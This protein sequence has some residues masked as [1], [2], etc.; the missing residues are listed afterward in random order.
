MRC[1]WKVN[2]SSFRGGAASSNASMD[3]AEIQEPSD[4]I[5]LDNLA[6]PAVFTWSA[7]ESAVLQDMVV[8][9]KAYGLDMQQ[10]WELS[11]LSEINL[12]D[13]YL[14][15]KTS[16]GGVCG[17]HAVF[18]SPRHG[19]FYCA[20]ARE[21][22]QTLLGPSLQHLRNALP[23]NPQ[24]RQNLDMIVDMLWSELL[25]PALTGSRDVEAGCF[26]TAMMQSQDRKQRE[27][28]ETARE[29]I[30]HD[31]QRDANFLQCK[32][33]VLRA[34]RKIFDPTLEESIIKPVAVALGLLPALNIGFLSSS[35]EVI[36]SSL[37]ENT[38]YDFLESAKWW[39]A[40]AAVW[41]VAGTQIEFPENG[42]Q[43]KYAAL[44]DARSCFDDLRY[45]FMVAS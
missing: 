10:E 2:S 31:Q 12:E 5:Q 22:A 13:T 23:D 41:C 29:N 25:L 6:S 38:H 34:T 1:Y 30:R 14:A 36:R 20:S 28:L 24:A 9:R 35:T 8:D 16:G 43:H 21:K 11:L 19:S 40:E 26:K 39:H 7:A 3:G 17:V 15:L 32:Q 42:P 33:T 18:G 4:P 45:G 37:E 27:I 44:F